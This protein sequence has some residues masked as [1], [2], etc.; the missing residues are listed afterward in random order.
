MNAR[1][2]ELHN[3]IESIH[4]ASCY[5]KRNIALGDTT[6]GFSGRL[7]ASDKYQMVTDRSDAMNVLIKTKMDC[8]STQQVI[9][10]STDASRQTTNITR[11]NSVF[12]SKNWTSFQ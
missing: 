5:F 2:I 6:L 11:N 12:F 3:T 10:L 8:E 4:Y 9:P 7:I 1:D